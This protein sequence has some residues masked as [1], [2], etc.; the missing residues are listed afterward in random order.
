ML[1]C[2]THALFWLREEN[3]NI[4]LF[5]LVTSVTIAEYVF[6]H[7]PSGAI[8]RQPILVSQSFSSCLSSTLCLGPLL[9]CLSRCT[10]STVFITH[11][12]GAHLTGP[13]PFSLVSKGLST[14]PRSCIATSYRQ[15]R[16]CSWFDVLQS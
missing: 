14:A 16:V 6:L 11:V 8:L 15:F 12:T 3:Y 9:G 13:S 4:K 7:F 10:S 2:L 1:W 5:I